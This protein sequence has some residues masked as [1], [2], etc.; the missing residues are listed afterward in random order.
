VFTTTPWLAFRCGHA[1]RVRKKHQVDFFA[2]IAVPFLVRDALEPVEVGHRRVVEQ[3]VDPPVGLHREIHQGLTLGRR[4]QPARMPGDHR[5]GVAANAIDGRLCR[6]NTQV[7]SD[8]RRALSGEGDG[9]LAADGP[10][11]AGDD[12]D[13]S[14]EPARHRDHP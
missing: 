12:A 1:A 2:K 9:G 8:D 5:S 13:L 7:A 4:G 6:V 11:R 10:A 3:H 14:C